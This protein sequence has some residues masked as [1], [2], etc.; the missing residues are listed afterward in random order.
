MLLQQ[1]SQNSVELH[2]PIPGD[3]DKCLIIIHADNNNGCLVSGNK[4]DIEI[5][6]ED[7]LGMQHLWDYLIDCDQKEH[8]GNLQLSLNDEYL[9]LSYEIWAGLFLALTNFFLVKEL[10]FIPDGGQ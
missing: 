9:T 5:N 6:V 10:G 1:I 3:V 2:R 4:V 7:T 8:K